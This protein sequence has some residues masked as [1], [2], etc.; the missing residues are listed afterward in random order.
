MLS[1][2][3]ELL[4]CKRCNIRKPVSDFT[5][6]SRTQNGLDYYCRS[7]KKEMYSKYGPVYKTS[8]IESRK[9]WYQ[10]NRDQILRKASESHL[11][12]IE[13]V[14]SRVKKYCSTTDGKEKRR[15]AMNRYY[16]ANAE[17]KM[18]VICRIVLARAVR[19]GK[20]IKP[21]ACRDCKTRCCPEAHH[22]DYSKPLEVIWLCKQCHSAL[23]RKHQ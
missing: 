13:K 2:T 17:N 10:E 15:K 12:N 6:N 19:S 5:K 11:K 23:K 21:S 9:Q 22:N 14:R 3:G 7:C 1:D 4:S 16:H 18:K 8:R 20:V